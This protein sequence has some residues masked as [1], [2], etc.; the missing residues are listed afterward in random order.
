MKHQTKL[1]LIDTAEK[2]GT[3]LIE[4]AIVYML[5]AQAYDGEFWRGLAV[6]VVIAVVNV[7][8]AAL[9]SWMPTPTDWRLD[10]VVRAGWTFI[11]SILG[12]LA[13]VTWLDIV[14]MQ[15]W[16]GVLL[17]AAVAALA[18]VKAFLARRL[19]SGRVSPASLVSA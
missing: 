5:A 1:W 18:V 10:M 4:A 15:F 11:I 8:K 2:A 9:T 12:S 7:L 13:S 19:P 3:T 14:D 16:R 17:A 6:A